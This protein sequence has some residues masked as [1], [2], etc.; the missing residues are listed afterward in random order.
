MAKKQTQTSSNSLYRKKGKKKGSFSKKQSS[1]KKSK[2][3]KKPYAGQG[4]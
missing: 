3:Y 4:R 2:N 1:N